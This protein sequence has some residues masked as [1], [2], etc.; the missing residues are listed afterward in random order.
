MPETIHPPSHPA[1]EAL[2][3][4]GAGLLREAFEPTVMWLSVNE[5]LSTRV[6]ISP[7]NG[8]L[9]CSDEVVTDLFR[10]LSDG[11]VR[12]DGDRFVLTDAGVERLQRLDRRATL[13]A[14][15]VAERAPQDVAEL[16]TDVER[17]RGD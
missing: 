10:G 15:R 4:S 7:S 17:K 11:L 3:A 1:L 9:A 12:L 13:A 16:L 5:G 14:R 6:Q 2:D 8:Q